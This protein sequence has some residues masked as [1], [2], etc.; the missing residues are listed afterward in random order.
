MRNENG[1]SLVQLVTDAMNEFATL[2][3]TEIHLLRVELSDKMS[4]IANSGTMIGAGAIAAIIGL[5][6]L[7]QAAVKWLAVAGLPEE[8]GLLLVGIVVAILGVV[9]LMSGINT[10]KS[11]T[12]LPERAM[13][14][15]RAD[16]ATVKE[17]VT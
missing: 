3:H 16:I 8:W 10:V 17:H 11:T 13:N 4:R 12:L 15:V 5:V 7:L 1:R 9:L 2:F 14:Q 6:L